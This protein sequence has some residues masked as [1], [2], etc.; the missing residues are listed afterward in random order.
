[1]DCDATKDDPGDCACDA[2]LSGPAK[3]L[4]MIMLY[5]DEPAIK[6]WQALMTPEQRGRTTWKR[7]PDGSKPEREVRDHPEGLL[8][9][10][11]RRLL[12]IPD[13]GLARAINVR[14]SEI[15][16]TLRRDE[17]ALAAK[18]ESAD[19][20][21][22]ELAEQ[23]YN[24][25]LSDKA[26]QDDVAKVLGEKLGEDDIDLNDDWHEWLKFAIEYATFKLDVEKRTGELAGD[27]RAFGIRDWSAPPFGGA[28]HVWLPS[29]R[30]LGRDAP[31]PLIA[32]GLRGRAADVHDSNMHICGEAYS[33][34]QGFIEGALRTAEEVVDRIAGDGQADAVFSLDKNNK[35][36]EKEATWIGKQPT[37]L[38]DRWDALP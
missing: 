12:V 35:A 33:G 32:F 14:E 2:R 13:P 21:T 29:A 4:G 36:K 24:A 31:D 17:P 15:M 18:I 7:Y 20:E 34:F 9:T 30:P 25:T 37:E 27:I 1:M 11:I 5:T 38:T 23:I 3:E 22:G 28:S 16:D 19:G 8:A 6:Y 26:G 10:L